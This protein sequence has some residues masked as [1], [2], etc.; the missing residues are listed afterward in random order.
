MGSWANSLHVKHADPA[1]VVEAVGNVLRA[2]GYGVDTR[3]RR[4][5][6]AGI[7][8]ALLAGQGLPEDEGPT[9][10]FPGEI[11]PR[12]ICVYKPAAGWVG[13]LDSG[14]INELAVAL[15]ER[16]ETDTIQVMVN[17]SDSWFYE[18]R[19]HGQLVDSFSSAG[20][21]DDGGLSPAMRAALDS[22]DENE[23]TRLAMERVRANAPQ[24]PIVLPDGGSMLPPEMALLRARILQ[25]QASFWE[26]WRYRLLWVR[27]LFRLVTGR[28]RPEGLQMGF[29]VPRQTPLDEATL[30]RHLRHLVSFFPDADGTVL[31]RVLSQSRFPAEELLAEFLATLGLP[32][33]YAYLN[34]S[35]LE[36]F[37]DGQLAHE[38]IRLARELRFDRA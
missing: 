5:A 28:W 29:D 6:A 22:G 37:T 17:D 7:L 27:L 26:R 36:D 15:S 32:R 30:E 20:E 13:I 9:D 35:Y 23:F 31:R 3:A 34:Y 18:L 11:G 21:E 8:T 19:R 1:A 10:A 24:G 2:R 38:G 33:F 12:G 25:G 16:L 4:P 14:D